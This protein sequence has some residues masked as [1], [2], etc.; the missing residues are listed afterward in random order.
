MDKTL[1]PLLY[2][3][4]TSLYNER[5]EVKKVPYVALERDIKLFVVDTVS[6]VLGDM[7]DDGIL[8]CHENLNGM[9][10]YSPINVGE[11]KI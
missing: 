1:Q 2:M 8:E 10:M 4:V 9:K 7:V 11:D 5:K 3:A 6:K